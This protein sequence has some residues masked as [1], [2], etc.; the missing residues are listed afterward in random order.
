MADKL[1]YHIE[2]E[3]VCSD[4]YPN[5][6]VAH[7]VSSA[8]IGD[9]YHRPHAKGADCCCP[10]GSWECIICNLWTLNSKEYCRGCFVVRAAVTGVQLYR[11]S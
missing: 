1:C 8:I 6:S 5:G 10:N 11:V 2:D 3:K 9:F 7:T 4:E